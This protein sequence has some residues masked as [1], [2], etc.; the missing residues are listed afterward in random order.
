MAEKEKRLTGEV[1][2]VAYDFCD[3]LVVFSN[4]LSSSSRPSETS[5][6]IQYSADGRLRAAAIPKLI[7]L[8]FEPSRTSTFTTSVFLLFCV[9]I[10]SFSIVD[11]QFTRQFLCAYYGFMT[12]AELL[13]LFI[14]KWN[15]IKS[16]ADA[17]AIRNR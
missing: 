13:D 15:S 9:L 3:S 7:D 14:Q 12:S 11:D 16:Q 4:I 1:S 10:A 6:D 8:L 2:A 17:K 5:A